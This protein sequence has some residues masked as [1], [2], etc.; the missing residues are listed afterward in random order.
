MFAPARKWL[1]VMSDTCRWRH[2]WSPDY[3][4]TKILEVYFS[5][6]LCN[7]YSYLILWIG[8]RA[9]GVAT[10]CVLTAYLHKS[11]APDVKGSMGRMHAEARANVNVFVLCQ[12]VTRI[13]AQRVFRGANT[14]HLS[15]IRQPS[16]SMKT[17]Q[18]LASFPWLS[19]QCV[20]RFFGWH[21]SCKNSLLLLDLLLAICVI[22]RM[23]GFMFPILASIDFLRWERTR[24]RWRHVLCCTTASQEIK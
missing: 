19:R 18:K 6:P 8:W 13:Y 20:S 5:M 12:C 11:L 17:L 16:E 7:V 21:Q 24:A 10:R 1:C 9:L 23:F 4:R 3:V 22:D 14:K 15:V 2:T